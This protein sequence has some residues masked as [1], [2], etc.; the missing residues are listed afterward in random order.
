MTFNYQCNFNVAVLRQGVVVWLGLPSA[1][2]CGNNI[3]L[4]AYLNVLN[5][6]V[7]NFYN[8]KTVINYLISF[9][10]LIG[11]GTYHSV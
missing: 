4:A 9:D 8:Y 1:M 5:D 7:I 3:K 11:A 6:Q 2:L 10:W